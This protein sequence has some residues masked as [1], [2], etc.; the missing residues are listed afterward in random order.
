MKLFLV[1]GI[2]AASLVLTGAQ[3]P[4]VRY[5]AD[6]VK[7]TIERADFEFANH[8]MYRDQ[9]A[10]INKTIAFYGEY[11]AKPVIVS[12]ARD[13]IQV[14]G[15]SST[16]DPANV[17]A[18]MDNPLPVTRGYGDRT[19]TIAKGDRIRVFGVLQKCRDFVDWSGTVRYLPT[20][21]CLIIYSRDDTEFRH[22]IWVSKSLK[23]GI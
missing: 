2:S 15:S 20:M 10:W 17:V 1:L 4:D 13:Y 8:L 6:A 22:P 14:S 23:R 3:D 5:D 18:F 7:K 12:E 19:Q 11:V 21:D 9:K 16:G